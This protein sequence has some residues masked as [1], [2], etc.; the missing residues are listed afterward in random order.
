VSYGVCE[1]FNGAAANQAFSTA[2]QTGVGGGMSIFVATGD[3]NSAD[4]NDNGSTYAGT[5]YGIGVDGWASTPYNVAV[6]GTDFSDTYAGTNST[7]WNS[8]NT[9]TYGSAKSYIPEIPWNDTC[10]S[11]LIATYFGYTTTYGS[12]GFCNS[13]AGADFLDLGGGEGGPSGCATGSPSTPDVVSGT[14]AGWPKPS[15]QS[16][17]LGNPAD[18]VRDLPDVSLFA[19][20]GAWNHYYVDCYSDSDFGGTPCSGAPS[21]WDSAGGTSFATPIWAGIQALIN[22][23]AGEKQGLPTY[24]LYQ[25]A[26]QEY[27]TSGSS[28][29]N[30]SNG[31]TV[32]SSCIFYDVTQG[33]N[34]ADCQS[35]TPNCYDPSGTYGV[36]ST[37]TSSYHYSCVFF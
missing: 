23:Q 24:R 36:L 11:Q 25:L 13:S 27:G 3:D 7:Y 21:T 20:S 10:A 8:T 26:F 37:S 2:Y 12:S 18:G 33:D 15:W 19:A 28:T 17:F 14:C 31:N 6:G 34:D 4:C 32:G 22:Q 5:T 30:A 1:A 16:G 9:P 29:C 35:G